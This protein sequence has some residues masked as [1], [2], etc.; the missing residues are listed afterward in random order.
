M[1]SQWDSS[2]RP[3]NRETNA[4]MTTRRWQLHTPC[5]I[6]PKTK[7]NF[8]L[9]FYAQLGSSK[10]AQCSKLKK[11]PPLNRLAKSPARQLARRVSRQV[12]SVVRP[13]TDRKLATRALYCDQLRLFSERPLERH[14]RGDSCTGC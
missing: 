9:Y 11:L 5:N 13:R 10:N 4:L 7:K 14:A 3:P 2:P 6:K 8:C 12:H 1:L